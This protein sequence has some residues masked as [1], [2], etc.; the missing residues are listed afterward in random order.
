MST[1][2]PATEQPS[3]PPTDATATD[4]SPTPL[5]RLLDET[6][7]LIDSPPFTHVLTK[8]LDAGFSVLVD[9]KLAVQAFK[10]TP[11]PTID[12]TSRIQEILPG[13]ENTAKTKVANVLAVMTR[14]A[15]SIGNGVP[16]EYLQA[17][18]DVRDLEG[19]AA[20]V[21]SSN[22][23]FEAPS[24]GAG[25]S[26]AA[27]EGGSRKDS[28]KGE[29]AKTS[30]MGGGE[31]KTNEMGGEQAKTSEMG[32]GEASLVGGESGFESVWGKATEGEGKGGEGAM[33]G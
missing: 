31:A 15:H 17:M 23:E 6:S 21:Y 12:S 25:S 24:S 16:N 10:I 26:S 14:Q 30:E 7:D 11:S 9:Q 22:F 33:V 3:P 19:F 32:G 2:A 4:P 20:I 29:E 13:S 1:S 18:E 28:G 27:T 8:L 5:R